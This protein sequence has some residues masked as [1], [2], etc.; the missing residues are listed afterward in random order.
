MAEILPKKSLG[1]H[2]LEDEPTLEYIAGLADIG[3]GDTVLEIG[4]GQGSLTEY[5]TADARKVIAIELDRNLANQ[6]AAGAPKNLEVVQ[7]DILK[8][9]LSKLP[10]NYKVVANIPYYLTGHLLRLFGSSANQPS[11]VVLLVQKEVAERIAARPGRMSILSVSLQLFYEPQLGR[12]VP[13]EMFTPPPKVNSQVVIL[14][15][16]REPL[17]NNLDT[18]KFIRVV[19]A[20]F[21]SPRK[22]LRS[23]LAAGLRVGVGQADELLAAAEINGDL[24][25]EKLSLAQWHKLYTQYSLK[26]DLRSLL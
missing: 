12:V 19:K 20:G 7:G 3:V 9:D 5:L 4:P 11:L 23:S 1:Q 25:A 8:Y 16:R 15:R 17:F 14:R 2:W 26:T 13:A 22:K 18:P 21:S 24:R 10:K 6:L